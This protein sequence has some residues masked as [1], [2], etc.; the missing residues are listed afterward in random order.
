MLGMITDFIDYVR[1][2]NIEQIVVAASKE[3]AELARSIQSSIIEEGA[4]CRIEHAAA[5]A[6]F[7]GD[8]V[9]IRP[10]T[11]VIVTL[12]EG[13]VFKK[14]S[15]LNQVFNFETEELKKRKEG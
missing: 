1:R 3:D 10:G 9:E 7:D 2:G 8:E 11:I 12:Y 6:I 14:P 15:I 5:K 13:H 4:S